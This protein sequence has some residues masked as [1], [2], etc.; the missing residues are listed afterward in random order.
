MVPLKKIRRKCLALKA[1]LGPRSCGEKSNLDIPPVNIIF[2]R[3]IDQRFQVKKE[4]RGIHRVPKWGKL[5]KRDMN[6][7]EKQICLRISTSAMLGET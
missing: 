5:I 1:I 4:R 2:D 7:L 3:F 6:R